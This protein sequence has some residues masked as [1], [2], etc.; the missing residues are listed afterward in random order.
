M[1]DQAARLGKSGLTVRLQL[2]SA[3]PD[4]T[5]EADGSTIGAT[6]AAVFLCNGYGPPGYFLETRKLLSTL[7]KPVVPTDFNQEKMQIASK[8]AAIQQI[9]RSS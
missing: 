1:Q 3:Q 5:A 2:R 9:S 4:S 7:G 8:S 6:H